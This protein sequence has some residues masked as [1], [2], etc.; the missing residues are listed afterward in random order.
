MGIS[1]GVEILY[2]KSR[3]EQKPKN[4]KEPRCFSTDVERYRAKD[5]L[6]N[7]MKDLLKKEIDSIDKKY[8][9]DDIIFI[10]FIG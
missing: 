10:K 7:N 6:S 2:V 5:N 9:F 3:I 8:N 1:V 4:P